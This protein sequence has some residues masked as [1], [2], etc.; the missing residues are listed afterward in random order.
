MLDPEARAVA[1]ELIR[2]PPGQR[3][4]FAVLTT[5]TLD[6]EAL[7]V[8]PLSVLAHPDG[9]FEALLAEPL[10]LHQA[11]REAGDR[12][13]VFVDETGI[14]IPRGARPLYAMLE[15]SVHAVRAP[16]GGVF[17]PKVWVVRFAPEDETADPRLRVAVLSRNLGFA[18]AWDVALAMEDSPGR[19]EEESSQDLG[20]FL[21]AL[22]GLSTH[23]LPDH[24]EARIEGL[25]DQASR[26]AFPAPKGF[27]SSVTFHA[28]GLAH[29][30]DKPKLPA[31]GDRAL[32]MAPFVNQGGLA[33]VTRAAERAAV[34]IS[35]PEELDRLP[36]AAIET[37]DEVL[38]LADAAAGEAEDSPASDGDPP[39]TPV[40]RPAGLHAKAIAV[41]RGSDVT[42]YVGSANLTGAALDGANVELMA[43]ITGPGWRRPGRAIEHFLDGFGKLC[44]TYQRA[45]G[46]DPDPVVVDAEA[47]LRRTRD[48]LV[49]SG[50]RV[51]GAASGEEWTLTLEGDIAPLP[52]GVEVSGWPVSIPESH[53]LPIQPRPVWTL[54]LTRLSSFVAFRLHSPVPDVDDLRFALRL[55]ADGL[56]ADRTYEI[57]RSLLDSPEKFLRFLR[58]LLGG[59]DAVTDWTGKPADPPDGPAWGAGLGGETVLEDLLRAASRDPERLAPVRRLIRDLRQTGEGRRVIPD[60]LFL[61]WNAVEEALEPSPNG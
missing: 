12:I 36:R 29:R 33:H 5:Y 38:V 47:R 45:P 30:R 28:L 19:R 39:E 35:R 11:I 26:T 18:R 58:A 25:A 44:E 49:G 52:E 1:F 41:E 21:S 48:L 37:W 42:W 6:L 16:H 13:H 3:L 10:W 54:P 53:A 7:L 56:P 4:D 59:L 51:R 40:V 32:A 14:A 50:L 60:D 55:P 57:L 46:P 24:V 17:H 23:E 27:R 20:Q 61:I 8:L 2:P 15:G 22:P 31:A 9:D 34:L 43:S